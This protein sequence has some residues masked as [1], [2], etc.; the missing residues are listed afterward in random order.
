MLVRHGNT[1]R[2]DDMSFD[3]LAL[4]PSRQPQTIPGRLRRPPIRL[5]VLPALVASVA[6]AIQQLEQRRLIGRKFL[7]RLT[8]DPR[9]DAGDQPSRLAYLDDGSERAILL[10]SGERSA[11]R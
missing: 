10:Q 11:Q 4:Q 5:I 3:T 8:I 9:N 2:V 7:Q 6:P 1:C